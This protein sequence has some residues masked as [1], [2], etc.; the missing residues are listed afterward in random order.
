[1]A[2]SHLVMPGHGQPF[3]NVT[4][5]CIDLAQ[6]HEERLLKT[7]EILSDRTMSVYE[8]AS[9]LFGELDDFH[10]FLGCAEA[11]AHLEYLVEEGL[12]EKDE[13]R[14]RLGAQTS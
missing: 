3:E 1:M 4:Q 13:N 5:R 11:N 2:S 8:V 9:E 6:H 12:V 10:V 14:Y 7:R